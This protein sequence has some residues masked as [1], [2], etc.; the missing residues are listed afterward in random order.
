MHHKSSHKVVSN[1]EETEKAVSD[2]MLTIINP[3]ESSN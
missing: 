1:T 2:R 3:I